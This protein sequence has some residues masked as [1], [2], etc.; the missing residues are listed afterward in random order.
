MRP[1]LTTMSLLVFCMA[2]VADDP[3]GKSPLPELKGEV[4]LTVVDWEQMQAKIAA[5]KGKVV[6]VDFWSNYC[7]PCLAEF[8]SLVKLQ[9][10]HPNDVVCTSLNMNYGG[11]KAKA[12][13]DEQKGEALE[14]L[15]KTGAKFPHY[16]SSVPDE[17]LSTM[18][19]ISLPA[20]RVYG[21]DGKLADTFVV[22]KRFGGNGDFTYDKHI[23]PFVQ[24]LL[25]EGRK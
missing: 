14:F 20:V 16:M 6:V 8:P 2:A 3:A 24:K 19:D 11:G 15:K 9:R 4:S 12:P 1:V 10:M 5:H 18:L 21:R 22:D 25:A 13:T 7:D 23:I 17:D